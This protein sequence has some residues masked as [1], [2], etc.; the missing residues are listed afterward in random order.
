MAKEVAAWCKECQ[1]CARG[2]VTKQP[3]ADVQP[4]PVP[5]QRFAHVHVDL[6][7]P[8][9]VSGEGFRYLFTMIDRSSR[10]LEA[11]PL[12]SMDA[13]ACV[14]ALVAGWVARFGVP[15]RITSDQGRQFTSGVWQRLCDRL[16]TTHIRT[17]AYHPQ[18]N[19]MVER[20]HRSLKEALKARLAS[21]DWP[22]HLP[23]VL[24]GLRTAPKEDSAVS[25]AELVYGAPL[26]L[27]AQLAADVETADDALRR[28]RAAMAPPPV[29]HAALRGPTEPPAALRAAS[30]V[31]VRRGGTLPPLSPPYDGPYAV[32]QRGPKFFKL[33]IGDR[34]EAVSVDRLKPHM[35]AAAA[36]AA[37]P[38]RRLGGPF[39]RA[40]ADHF[41]P[42]A[43]I[44]LWR[45]AAA[46]RPAGDDSHPDHRLS[47]PS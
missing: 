16:G 8:L 10:W 29:R 38:R 23:W 39:W 40:W 24:L 25:S 9:P 47:S 43:P 11:V 21:V 5:S 32:L 12:P 4:I 26:T 3:A 7:G 41:R 17:T 33:Q 6:V 37:Q 1:P 18:A 20:A 44:H 46:V 15:G 36:A 19:G 45:L 22:Q 30:L 14:D 2:K 42:G 34:E 35:G 31:Y 13:E 27:P 28:S